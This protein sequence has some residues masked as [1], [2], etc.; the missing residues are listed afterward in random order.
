MTHQQLLNNRLQFITHHRDRLEKLRGIDLYHSQHDFFKTA[1]LFDKTVIGNVPLDFT[2]HV[3]EWLDIDDGFLKE[4]GWKYKESM[5][6]MPLAGDPENWSTNPDVTITKAKDEE[7]I[8]QFCL[9][10]SRG[11]NEEGTEDE[12]YPIMLKS[13]LKNYQNSNHQF[14]LAHAVGQLAGVTLAYYHDGII[15]IYSVTTISKYREIGVS[16]SLMKAAVEDGLRQNVEGITLQVTKGSYAEKFY[17]KLG[18]E[19]A[20]ECRMYKHAN[21]L[22]ANPR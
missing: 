6:Y 12:W 9:T 22:N 5:I 13:A 10:Q 15:G 21:A 18:F 8:Q 19:A 11:F 17:R 2:L 4:K 1:F 3:T 7:A 16:T 14:Y 20:F